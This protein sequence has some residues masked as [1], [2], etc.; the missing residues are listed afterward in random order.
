MLSGVHCLF[1]GV[2]L[3]NLCWSTLGLQSL[4]SLCSWWCCRTFGSWQKSFPGLPLPQHIRGEFPQTLPHLSRWDA[5]G[6]HCAQWRVWTAK[7]ALMG[8]ICAPAQY[9][10]VL[11]LYCT[12]GKFPGR[13]HTEPG[14][15]LT[16]ALYSN[17]FA[18]SSLR[19][20]FV[21]FGGSLLPIECHEY[22]LAEGHKGNIW[23][24]FPGNFFFCL[25]GMWYKS[26]IHIWFM[27]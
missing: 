10:K 19:W 13:L 4:C 6:S 1:L 25:S 2:S 18:I 24:C 26:N 21:A 12:P 22:L 15:S 27:L 17:G 8:Q 20:S 3:V 7:F 23:L 14:A 5:L 11:L 9:S 16:F